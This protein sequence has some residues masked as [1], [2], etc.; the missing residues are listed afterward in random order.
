MPK[1]ARGMPSPRAATMIKLVGAPATAASPPTRSPATKPVTIPGIFSSRKT[2]TGYSPTLQDGPEGEVAVGQHP[3][4]EDRRER[5]QNVDDYVRPDL[6]RQQQVVGPQQQQAVRSHREGREHREDV[7]DGGGAVL[8]TRNEQHGDPEQ[9][10]EP[11]EHEV[12]PVHPET[13]RGPDEV[14]RHIRLAAGEGIEDAERHLPADDR[15]EDE[16]QAAHDRPARLG[17]GCGHAVERGPLVVGQDGVPH[18]GV[19][20]HRALSEDGVDDGGQHRYAPEQHPGVEVHPAPPPLPA[21]HVLWIIGVEHVAPGGHGLLFVHVG[22]ALD[23]GDVCPHA[24]PLVPQPE[25]VPHL[26]HPRRTGEGDGPHYQREKL[27]GLGTTDRFLREIPEGKQARD[28]SPNE[29]QVTY[30]RRYDRGTDHEYADEGR[31]NRF[32]NVVYDRREADYE[33]DE[34]QAGY[35]EYVPADARQALERLSPE[36]HVAR[37]DVDQHRYGEEQPHYWPAQAGRPEEDALAG[38]RRVAGHLQNDDSL[39]R[40][41]NKE[42]PADLRPEEYDEPRPQI[43][44]A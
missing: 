1:I 42:E 6:P 33:A 27:G 26:L 29:S 4:V 5:Q 36:R 39:Q 12:E 16:E 24:G 11:Q 21:L 44:L 8:L 35:A 28:S 38:G 40:D 22:Q 15:D 32:D 13:L 2:R 23:P 19:D 3:E 31:Q 25:R 18:A 17:K 9:D 10:E 14:V 30:Q 37:Q 34:D 7:E 43:R 20:L 41:A